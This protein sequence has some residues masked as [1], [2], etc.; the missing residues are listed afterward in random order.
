MSWEPNHTENSERAF[1]H[2]AGPTI[3]G[4]TYQASP[5][6]DGAIHRDASEDSS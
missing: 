4:A 2:D 6:K 3:E 1:Y 5:L